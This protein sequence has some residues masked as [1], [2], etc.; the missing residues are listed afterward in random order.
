MKDFKF[1]EP[2]LSKGYF[3]PPF[4]ELQEMKEEKEKA[5]R[6]QQFVHDWKIAIVSLLG[7]AISGF[8]TSLFFGY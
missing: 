6:H 8:I 7:G 1:R 5:L 2:E 4:V 3:V